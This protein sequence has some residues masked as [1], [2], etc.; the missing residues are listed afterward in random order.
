MTDKKKR[1][2]FTVCAYALFWIVLA[3]MGVAII[4]GLLASEGTLFNVFVTI[5]AWTPTFALLVLFK[6]LFPESSIK[7]F[8]KEA[9]KQQLNWGIILSITVFQVLIFIGVTG[10]LAFTK[11][12]SFY[13]LFDLSL[14]T[15]GMGFF[16]SIIQGA[17]GEESGWRGFLQSS[18]EK[19]TGVI[20]SSIIVGLIWGFW[21][22]PLWFMDTEFVGIELVQWILVFLIAVISCSIIIGICY[23]RCRNLFVPIWIHFMFNFLSFLSF[24]YIG[25][26]LGYI[27][28]AA[29]F[30]AVTA[31]GYIVWYNRLVR[32]PSQVC[33]LCSLNISLAMWKMDI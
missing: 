28:W 5:A 33:C 12:I 32:L 4:T 26:S 13:N 16:W 1:V 22:M 30:Y 14:K 27:T 8:F 20:K 10:V 29:M 7:N 3:L 23:K 2:L 21:H 17:M 24:I 6:R 15:I 25:D 11:D 18:F 9:F 31:I 19:N